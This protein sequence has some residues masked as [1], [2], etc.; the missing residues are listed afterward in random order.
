MQVQGNE[1]MYTGVWQVRWGCHLERVLRVQAVRRRAG[2]A[3]S[4]CRGHFCN[5]RY[6]TGKLQQTIQQRK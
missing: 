4:F 1:K 2:S 5:R 3:G 6:S